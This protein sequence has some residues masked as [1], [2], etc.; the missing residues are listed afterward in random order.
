[1]HYMGAFT[2]YMREVSVYRSGILFNEKEL[3]C[4]L[5][6]ANPMA[7]PSSDVLCAAE[8]TNFPASVHIRFFEDVFSVLLG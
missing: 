3:A 6:A 5:L 2:M 7:N 8:A 4:T 1:M